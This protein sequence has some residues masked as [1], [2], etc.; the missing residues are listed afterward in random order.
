MEALNNLARIGE[1][2]PEPAHAGEFNGLVQSAHAL[3]LAALRWHGFRST[4][5]YQVFQC[6]T[7]TVNLSAEKA[8]IFPQ[9]DNRRN[10]AEYEGHLEIEQTLLSEFTKLTNEL[11]KTIA[12]LEPIE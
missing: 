6:L 11:L 10:I 12:A 4:N 3:A 2:H 5:R 8:Q 1:I 9:C 7:H